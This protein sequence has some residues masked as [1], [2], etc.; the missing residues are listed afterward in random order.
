ML[1]CVSVW[2]TP[3]PGP[4]VR[5]V[6]APVW[7]GGNRE[8]AGCLVSCAEKTVLCSSSKGLGVLTAGTW[9]AGTEGRVTGYLSQQLGWGAPAW[10][11][12]AQEWR[13][14]M[15]CS[16]TTDV[17]MYR[18]MHL[19]PCVLFSG[20]VHCH[21]SCRTLSSSP[22][23]TVPREPSPPPPAG[24]PR[25]LRETAGLLSVCGLADTGHVCGV[26]GSVGV[27]GPTSWELRRC[28]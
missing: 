4:H 24:L 6:A 28:F 27:F 12:I 10:Q 8:G 20:E 14:C 15:I 1:P 18:D 22:E 3:C 21:H 19:R 5:V 16:A 17:G 7:L 23:E 26:N 11:L 25:P 2:A 13:N 9:C